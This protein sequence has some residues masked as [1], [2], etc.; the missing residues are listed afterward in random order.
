MK[1]KQAVALCIEAL[2]RHCE[3]SILSIDVGI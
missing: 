1:R 3:Q 2:I